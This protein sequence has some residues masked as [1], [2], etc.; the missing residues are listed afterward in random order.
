VP[1]RG[2]RR[3]DSTHV[4]GLLAHLGRLEKLRE[5]I[6]L[7]MVELRK[8]EGV[9]LPEFWERMWELYVQS[10]PEWEAEKS[11]AE[12]RCQAVGRDMLLLVGWVGEQVEG[13]REGK[14]AKLLVRVFAENFTVEEQRV[15]L[16]AAEAGTVLNPHEPEAQV[17]RKRNKT[18][19]GFKAQVG[20]SIDEKAREA[21]EPKEQFI[22]SIVTTSASASDQQALEQVREEEK[23]SGLETAEQLHVDSGYISG[24]NIRECQ[25][26]GTELVGPVAKHGDNGKGFKSEQFAVDIGNQLAV[27]PAGQSSRRMSVSVHS[28]RPESRYC[29]F[30]WDTKVCRACPMGQQCMGRK[31]G[32]KVCG[33]TLEVG[34]DHEYVQRRR[35]E[36][37]TV[38]YQKRMRRRNA[39]EGTQSE[40]VRAHG[41]RQ[42]RYR[43]EGKVRMQ[44]YLIGAACNVKRWIRRVAWE[45][46]AAMKAAV[47]PEVA[48]E[49]VMA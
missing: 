24:S 9:K 1:R 25:E 43:G 30:V 39:I 34:E 29:R 11:A 18:W 22:T 46:R 49:V 19:S 13:V 10:K 8:G 41:L 7:G 36:Q 45:V 4:L 5:T 28:D 38:E 17:G 44:N 20:E 23:A 42:A 14:Q 40:L 31:A 16:K 3:L 21:G 32:E 37:K 48:V 35:A 15:Q 12:A 26:A 47:R 33:R 2:M 27:C 6:R